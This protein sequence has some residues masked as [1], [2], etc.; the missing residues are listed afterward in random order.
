MERE[1]FYSDAKRYKF[2]KIR[3][4][5]ISKLLEKEGKRTILMRSINNTGAKSR[6]SFVSLGTYVLM[7]GNQVGNFFFFSD[8]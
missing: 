5:S 8:S 1:W 7:V 2:F 4:I 3:E 6:G